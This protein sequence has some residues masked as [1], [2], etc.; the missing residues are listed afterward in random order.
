MTCDIMT[1]PAW[2]DVTIMTLSPSSPLR[3][4]HE[5]PCPDNISIDPNYW[6]VGKSI[7]QILTSLFQ[8]KE[9]V[10][11]ILFVFDF[12]CVFVRSKVSTHWA[13]LNRLRTNNLQIP[14]MQAKRPPSSF[15]IWVFSPRLENIFQQSE[16]PVDRR[17]WIWQRP[18]FHIF[19]SLDISICSHS[20][21]S[22]CKLDFIRLSNRLWKFDQNFTKV[23]SLKPPEL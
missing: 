20:G 15:F 21:S 10:A 6:S 7:S 2:Q 14:P 1:F 5:N 13:D 23:L 17:N 18:T 12:I 16:N 8:I 11:V 4:E 19:T 3:H 22:A 9:F